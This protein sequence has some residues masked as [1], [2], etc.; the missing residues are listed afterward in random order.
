MIINL[1]P[2]FTELIKGIGFVQEDPKKVSTEATIAD[3]MEGFFYWTYNG[4]SIVIATY[5][6]GGEYRWSISKDSTEIHRTNGVLSEFT[7]RNWLSFES[8]EIRFQRNFLLDEI[9]LL[10]IHFKPELRDAKLKELGC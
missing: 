9:E 6:D 1:L 2:K 5:A 7:K 4:Y 10:E 8:K 3:F